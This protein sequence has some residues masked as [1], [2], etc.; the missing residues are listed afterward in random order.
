METNNKINDELIAKY[1]SGKT[2]EEE[3]ILIHDYLAR[4][5]KFADELLDITTAIQY[6]HKH[7]EESH[8]A[9][10][11]QSKAKS[12]FSMPPRTFFS[13]A[14]SI[15]LAIGI[16][17]LVFKPFS[18]NN[19]GPTIVENSTETNTVTTNPINETTTKSGTTPI[20]SIEPEAPS[21]ADNQESTVLPVETVSQSQLD[22]TF[23]ADNTS[24]NAQLS[25][26]TSALSTNPDGPMMASLTVHGDN[27]DAPMMKEALFIADSIPNTCNPTKALIMKW[28]CNAPILTLEISYGKDKKWEKTF[29]TSASQTTIH[30]RQLSEFK[31]YNPQGFNWRLTAHYRDG[32][33]TKEGFISFTNDND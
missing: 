6:Q 30:P 3:E 8:K 7:D 25:Q 4:N 28:D 20:G 17:F 16:G 12:I 21:L 23:L 9:S 15:A 19:Q 2:T 31:A 32:K 26:E 5:P 24:T 22:Q 11:G 27:H 33:L 29:N 18:N 1:L 14:A 10:E 13:A